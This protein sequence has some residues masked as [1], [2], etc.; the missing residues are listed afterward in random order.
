V[1]GGR[2]S[3]YSFSR[4][5]LIIPLSFVPPKSFNCTTPPSLTVFTLYGSNQCIL[6]FPG[7]WRDLLSYT[8]TKSTSLKFFLLICLSCQALSLSFYT[9]WWNPARI[10]Y[11]S[12]IIS[13]F[14][15]SC[16]ASRSVMF[17]IDATRG[18]VTKKYN[19]TTASCPY[20][21][22]NGV[23]HVKCFHVVLYAH[24]I[25]GIFKS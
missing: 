19:A 17:L 9:S 16:T 6:S 15:L 4:L 5:P 20:T 10:L 8:K 25:V 1:L 21:N 11:S 13:W 12:M 2:L 18:L 14:S 24:S 22:L 7:C 23:Y 3:L